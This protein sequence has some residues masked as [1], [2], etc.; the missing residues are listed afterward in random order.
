[1]TFCKNCGNQLDENTK[2]CPKCG[3]P[4]KQTSLSE[5]TETDSIQNKTVKHSSNIYGKINLED[6]PKGHL[7]DNRYEIKEKIGQGGFGA[8]YRV[9]DKK[10]NIEKALKIIPEAIVN[11]E[12]A[13]TD[14]QNES[15]TMIALNHPNIVR[16]YDFHDE[17][18]IKYIDME[19]IDGK[20]LTKI[21]LEH[22]NKQI[23]EEKVKEY[24]IKIAEGLAYAHA[25]NVIHKDIKPQNIM[26]NKKG[27]MKIMDF[28]IA[29]TVRTTMSRL[30]NSSSSGTLVYMSPEQ[31]RGKNVGKESDIYSFGA[32]L[33]ELLSGHPPFYKGDINYQIINEKP[34]KLDFVSDTID[35]MLM[36]CL[37]KEYKDRF[38]NFE[39]IILFIS[40]RSKKNK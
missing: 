10:M 31:L 37:E 7:I 24:A 13:M 18:E 16:V 30:Q 26:L 1:M 38:S 35:K 11:D 4:I 34:E 22:Q 5:K 19:F 32:M 29:E 17:G 14:L 39:E 9:L 33:Y 25:N 28:G 3:T 8:I 12:E 21:K 6:L 20:T 15:R 40:E 36:K 27:E 23:P 2:F